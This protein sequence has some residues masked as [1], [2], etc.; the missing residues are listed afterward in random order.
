MENYD[1]GHNQ[2]LSKLG[3]SN[4]VFTTTTTPLLSGQTP[5]TSLFIIISSNLS[6]YRTGY[7]LN[8]PELFVSVHL[9]VFQTQF[10]WFLDEIIH[11]DFHT[12]DL[13]KNNELQNQAFKNCCD[14]II[15]LNLVTLKTKLL[16]CSMAL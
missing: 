15:V 4:L 14:S 5:N 1:Y 13:R 12:L 9:L 3:M 16:I 7:Y 2:S 6:L 11:L 8:I 10:S